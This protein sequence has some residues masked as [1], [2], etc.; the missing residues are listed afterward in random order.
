MQENVI[1]LTA[2]IALVGSLFG[3]IKANF[4]DS[5]DKHKPKYV[6]LFNILLGVFCGV[7]LSLNYAN[8]LTLWL[9][10]LVGLTSS[11]ISLVVLDS[12]YTLAPMI[13]DK[14]VRKRFGLKK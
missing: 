3:A 13:V 11:M 1:D 9:V 4:N 14:L 10:G 2:V 7:M 5:D 12:L 6:K 8:Q